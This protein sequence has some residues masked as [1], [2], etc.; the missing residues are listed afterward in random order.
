MKIVVI[1]AG[2]MGTLFGGRLGLAGNQV[3]LVDVV[4]EVI[5]AVNENGICLE[6]DAGTHIARV[7]ASRAEEIT[8]PADLV[9]LFTKTLYSESALQSAQAFIGDETRVM[10]L[11]NGLGNDEILKKYVDP[12]RILIGVTNYPSDFLG[13]GHVSSKGDGYIR[14]MSLKDGDPASDIVSVLR[15]A[16]FNASAVDNVFDSIWEKVAFNAVFNSITSVCGITVDEVGHTEEGLRLAET[17]A[18][19]IVA[20]ARACGADLKKEALWEGILYAVKNHIG[21]RTSMAQDIQKHRRTEVDSIVGA[22]LRKAAENDLSAP[23]LE[24][25]YQMVKIVECHSCGQ[26]RN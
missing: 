2:A 6:D 10:S 20:V 19:E 7:S 16:G 8:E 1:G 14:L 17:L 23:H 18:D 3:C 22:I 21:H 12:E 9:I 4:P 24:T 15:E 5:R 26:V 11:Q 25:V 13:P